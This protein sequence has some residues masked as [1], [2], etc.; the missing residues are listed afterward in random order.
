MHPARI[1]KALVFASNANEPEKKIDDKYTATDNRL[2][3]TTKSLSIQQNFHEILACH[4]NRGRNTR[5]VQFFGS[6]LKSESCCTLLIS[7]DIIFSC[8]T[9]TGYSPTHYSRFRSIIQQ[10]SCGKNGEAKVVGFVI[11]ELSQRNY[12]WNK[13]KSLVI[14]RESLNFCCVCLS[15]YNISYE[16]RL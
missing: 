16:V 8:I 4:N 5:N 12:S 9:F 1:L 3:S 13:S 15:V 6:T 11:S 14:S 10:K 7:C 2:S